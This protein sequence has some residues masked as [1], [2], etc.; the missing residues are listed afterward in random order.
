MSSA[1]RESVRREESFGRRRPFYRRLGFQEA[2]YGILLAS[3]AILGIIFFTALPILTS[4]YLSFTDYDI[5]SPP[6]WVFLKNYTKML[7][8]NELFTKSLGITSYYSALTVPLSLIIGFLVA[9]LMN[10]KVTGCTSS[11]RSGTFRRSSPRLP[12][13]RSGAGCSIETSG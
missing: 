1:Q 13:P 12:T 5:V 11:G 10:Q 2:S 6:K 3:P 8:D 9:I 7:T 4:L